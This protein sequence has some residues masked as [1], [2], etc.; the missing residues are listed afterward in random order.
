MAALAI[1]TQTGHPDAH[2]AGVVAITT[3]A[4]LAI[5]LVGLLLSSRFRWFV[6]YPLR[7]AAPLAPVVSF[8]WAPAPSRHDAEPASRASSESTLNLAQKRDDEMR[9]S[10]QRFRE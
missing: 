9:A 4:L 2:L 3:A 1:L 10:E 6:S 7:G 8:M 5:A